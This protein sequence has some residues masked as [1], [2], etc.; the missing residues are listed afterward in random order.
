MDWIN[1]IDLSDAVECIY[2]QTLSPSSAPNRISRRFG[3]PSSR[4]QAQR[5]E[6]R[7]SEVICCPLVASFDVADCSTARLG[8]KREGHETSR[9]LDRED[10]ESNHRWVAWLT[11]A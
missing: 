9:V 6:Q 10:G 1:S 2:C 7:V 11:K 5:R 8:T 4:D 3:R